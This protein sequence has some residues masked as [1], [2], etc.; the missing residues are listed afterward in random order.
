MDTLN[1]AE[2]EIKR[3]LAPNN[4]TIAIL[5]VDPPEVVEKLTQVEDDDNEVHF[6]VHLDQ[7]QVNDTVDQVHFNDTADNLLPSGHPQIVTKNLNEAPN[8]AS[9]AFSK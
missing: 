4:K 6:G 9:K 1:K 5:P 3:S 2:V 8:I 7:G